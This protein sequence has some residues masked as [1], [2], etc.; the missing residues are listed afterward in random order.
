M[1]PL[2]E[3]AIPQLKRILPLPEPDIKQII[4]YSLSLS[5]PDSAEHLKNLLGDSAQSFEFISSFNS[6][7]ETDPKSTHRPPSNNPS[8]HRRPNEGWSQETPPR[9][10]RDDGTTAKSTRRQ[11]QKASSA[12]SVALSSTPD[13]VQLPSKMPPSASGPL[14]SDLKQPARQPSPGPRR[15]NNTINVSGGTSMRGDSSSI[16]DLDQ[17]IRSLEVATNPSLSRKA[18]N[19][20]ATRHPLLVSAPNC[21]NCGKIVCVKEGFGPCTYCGQPLLSGEDIQL[22]ITSLREERGREKMEVNNASQKRSEVSKTPRPFTA[23]SS[24]LASAQEHRD[25]L[26]NFQ[27]TSAKRTQVHDEAADFETPSSGQSIWATPQERAL[28]LK[29]QQKALRGQQW[30][31]KQDYEKR[32]QVVSIDIVGGKAVKKMMTIQHEDSSSTEEEES[33]KIQTSGDEARGTFS[34]NPLLGGMIRPT[35]HADKGKDVDRTGN[36]VP[37]KREKTWRR[38]Q[39]DLDDNETIILESGL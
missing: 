19:C 14:I 10:H 3:W 30:N 33:G 6:R 9:S 28:Q 1:A 21:L 15:K 38:V 34:R 11:R 32:Q 5:R 20:N 27:E 8:P 31:A 25:K 16:N 29:R 2:A 13:A 18:C 17:A 23:S 22:M 26:L 4:D 39:N 12:K 37:G 7:R 24:A 36:D 35:Y